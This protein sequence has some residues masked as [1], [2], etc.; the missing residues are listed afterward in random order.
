MDL[1]WLAELA[2]EFG[3]SGDLR[4]AVSPSGAVIAYAGPVVI[5]VH[6]ARTDP[7]LLLARLR[8]AADLS[9]ADVL[10]APISIAVHRTPDG[11]SA[12]VWP[13]LE[14]LHPTDR[15]P[16]ASAG[17][18]LARLHLVDRGPIAS[19]PLSARSPGSSGRW[20]GSPRP[21]LLRLCFSASAQRSSGRP[22]RRPPTVDWSTVTGI[23][24]SWAVPQAGSGSC[25][26]STTSV[27]GTRSGI[28]GA[29]PASGQ[30][31]C[32]PTLSG[33]PSWSPTGARVVPL[34]RQTAIPGA[35]GPAR[36]RCRRDGGLP[37]SQPPGC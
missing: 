11:R 28:W 10:A 1:T 25:S 15:P 35:L 2:S 9:P 23:S 31:A 3:G 24:V 18:L 8:L 5:K 32:S 13:R 37:S 36:A 34:C 17:T 21:H 14:V 4:T 27:E 26:T 19:L 16:W 20:A 7:T 30:P 29:Q 12:T 22:C 33:T 6:H